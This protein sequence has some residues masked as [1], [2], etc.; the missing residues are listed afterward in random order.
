MKSHRHLRAT[1]RSCSA[2]S[3]WS[4]S[5]LR[6]REL[7]GLRE[8]L[9]GK[10]PPGYMNDPTVAGMIRPS[11]ENPRIDV[12]VW[13]VGWS[14]VKEEDG[15]LFVYCNTPLISESVDEDSWARIQDRMR[16]VNHIIS[17]MMCRLLGEA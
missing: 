16:R 5:I 3:C 2:T 12:H 8:E 17:G 7:A 13:T 1:S 14:V 10:N 9:L 4:S 11:L 15:T 6:R